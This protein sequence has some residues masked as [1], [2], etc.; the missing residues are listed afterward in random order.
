MLSNSKFKFFKLLSDNLLVK[1]LGDDVFTFYRGVFEI[2]HNF[3]KT[4]LFS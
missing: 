4:D 1:F 2:V 3:Y